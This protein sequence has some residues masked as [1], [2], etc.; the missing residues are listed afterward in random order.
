LPTPSSCEQYRVLAQNQ[1]VHAV[2]HLPAGTVAAVFF[3][4]AK[5][6][7]V[8]T[9]RSFVESASVPCAL[10]VQRSNQGVS[11]TLSNPRFGWLADGE[12]FN[13]N[14]ATAHEREKRPTAA[15][16]TAL[17]IMGLWRVSSFSVVDGMGM[18]AFVTN[19]TA[20]VVQAD[21]SCA[22]T[23]L[24][25]TSSYGQ[26]VTVLL[27]E[28]AGTPGCTTSTTTTTTACQPQMESYLVQ[29]SADSHVRCAGHALWVP[30]SNG[31]RGGKWGGLGDN[32]DED[33]CQ[34]LC[35]DQDGCKYALCKLDSN[36]NCRQCS[37]FSTCEGPRRQNC[38]T[39]K[40]FK[41]TICDDAA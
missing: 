31:A 5:A 35:L 23:D 16:T 11:L 2:E 14:A 41:K 15:Q 10:I 38:C 8:L 1:V 20:V 40:I 36:G 27:E 19:A 6:P 3:A 12:T 33:T 4:A 32:V 26:S 25:V 22:T 18:A 28:V 29:G 17:R 24:H 7:D 9:N 13:T 39:F 30:R 34:K 37:A 21:R